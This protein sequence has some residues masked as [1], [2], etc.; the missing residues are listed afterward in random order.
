VS[1]PRGEQTQH[2]FQF[3]KILLSSRIG[4]LP[5]LASGIFFGYGGVTLKAAAVASP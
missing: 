4:R 3:Q 5:H 1:A 2:K